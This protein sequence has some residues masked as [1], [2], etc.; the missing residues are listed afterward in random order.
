MLYIQ[1][2]VEYLHW[3]V[4]TCNIDFEMADYWIWHTEVL[5]DL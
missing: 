1:T 3:R 5:E 2:D 4:S